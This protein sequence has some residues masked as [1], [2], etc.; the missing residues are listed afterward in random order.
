V[1]MQHYADIGRQIRAILLSF[2]P[3]VEPLSL[4]EAFLDVRGCEGLFGPAVHMARSI[5]QRIFSETA[6]VASVGVAPNK[7]LAKL[8]SDHGKPN[9]LVAVPPE[10]VNSFLEPLP[11]GRIWWI[12]AKTEQ[13][14]HE[15]GICTIGQLAALPEQV[16]ADH[17]GRA[18][19]HI[20]QLS[21]GDDDRTVV[22]DREA[23]SI[24]TETTFAENIG[25]HA[26][27]TDWLLEQVE[28]TATR[29]RQ[30]G[31]K[32]GTVQLKLRSSAFRTRVRSMSLGEVTGSTQ[33]LWQAARSLLERS[34]TAD[35]LPL[36]L[37][38]IGVTNL[39]R[40]GAVQADLFE[41]AERK[42]QETLDQTIDQ[43]RRQ[44]GKTAVQRGS[45]LHRKN[46]RESDPSA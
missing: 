35:I 44:L 32:A 28:Q 29:L 17:F 42:R 41:S 10:Q 8:A 5:K 39:V 30:A 7:F 43:I 9:G 36:R 38:G 4:D 24:S 19:R 37:L 40:E 22:P 13:R 27:L 46:N 25:D 45:V 31:A 23:K 14:L 26:V 16:L 2:T 11:V 15:I 3:L 33:A 1:R 21:H 6:L 34:L 12:G 20:W 18:G